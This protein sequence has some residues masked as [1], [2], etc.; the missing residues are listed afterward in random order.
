MTSSKKFALITGG[1]RRIG[2]AICRNLHKAGIDIMIHYRNSKEDA[3]TLQKELSNIGEDTT[4]LV[5]A[6]LLEFQSYE[7][8]IK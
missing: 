5:Q 1:S 8:I 4:C 3:I 2:A 7:Y 6:N